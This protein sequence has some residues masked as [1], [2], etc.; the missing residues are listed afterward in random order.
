MSATGKQINQETAIT[1]PA[2]TDL[3]L[4]DTGGSPFVTK[5]CTLANALAGAVGTP[6]KNL[7]FA[8][9]GTGS[10]AAP[11]WRALVAAELGTAM[12]PQFAKA[13]IGVAADAS[14]CLLVNNTTI[15]PGI[16]VAALSVV[17]KGGLANDDVSVFQ[18]DATT[19]NPYF[20]LGQV[21]VD[22]G[23]IFQFKKTW[24]GGPVLIFAVHGASGSI[25]VSNTGK[26][27][28]EGGFAVNAVDGASATVSAADLSTQSLNFSGGLFTGLV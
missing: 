23:G 6:A 24:H 11:T 14:I 13:G 10:D 12:T 5:K 21:A 2:S 20:T 9:P 22:G 28:A 18:C 25:V 27:T 15:N 1:S 3:L 8:V 17:H 19:G 7:V 16:S 26:L 4:L